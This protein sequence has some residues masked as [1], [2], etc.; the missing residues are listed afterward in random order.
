MAL[1]KFF[2]QLEIDRV[3]KLCLA[4]ETDE[5]MFWRLLRGQ[6]S[7]SQ[8]SPFLVNGRLITN[9]NDIHDM[10]A[11]HF[12]A[13]GTPTVNL[14]FD[15]EFADLISTH[16]QTTF[17]NCT[18]DSTVALSGPLT[19]E[20]VATICSNLKPRVSGVLLD[21]KHIRYTGPSLW[22]LLYHMY[23]QVFES[24][25]ACKSLK[26]GIIFPLFKDKGAKAN[27]KDNYRGITL[28]PTLCKI[29]EMILL[30]RLE[31]FAIDNE[32]FSELQF[33]FRRG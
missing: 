24:S 23:Q 9:E 8:M 12:K 25:V 13:L 7:S 5:K 27:N 26:I 28:F 1:H 22:R 33:G 31:K 2:N 11:D 15:N 10:W 16:V 6:R 19:Y 18:S 3:R 14:N 17:K 21:N 32:Y 29:Y 4:A 30:N 20:E